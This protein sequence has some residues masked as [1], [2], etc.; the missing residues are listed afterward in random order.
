MYDMPV[1]GWRRNPSLLL[2]IPPH[3]SPRRE[4]KLI[5]ELL[6]FFKIFKT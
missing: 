3:P 2:H 6:M 4:Y 1:N 5:V